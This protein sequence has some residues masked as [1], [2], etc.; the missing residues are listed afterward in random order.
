MVYGFLGIGFLLL[1]IGSNAVLRSGAGLFKTLGLPSNFAALLIASFAMST[2]ELSVALQAGVRGLPDIALGDIIGSTIANL[3]LI[4]GLGALLR[5]LPGS[6]RT[7]FRDGGAL[8]LASIVFA[9]GMF[10]GSIGR[11]LGVA[12]LAG[13]AVYLLLVYVTDLRR[14][15]PSSPHEAQAGVEERIYGGG[16]GVFLFAFGLICVFFGAR[17]ATDFAI[18]A[19]R[20]FHLSQAGASLTLVAF[21]TSLPELVSTLGSAARRDLNRISGNLMASSVFNILLVLGIAACTAPL[22]VTSMLADFDGPFMAASAIVVAVL[23]LSG[24]R[25][26]RG[27]GAILLVFYAVYLCSIGLRSGMLFH[28]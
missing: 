1:L 23:M 15:P 25:L 24:W 14:V 19:A 18:V 8:I 26:T 2:P 11:P 21:G 4:F 3:L 13:L 28:L 17:L 20:D 6:P 27:Q 16:F 7:V 9:G 5:P 10:G 12:L 22:S